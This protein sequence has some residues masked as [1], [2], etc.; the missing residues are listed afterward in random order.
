MQKS[1]DG[2]LLDTDV[3]QSSAKQ[4]ERAEWSCHSSDS[5]Q[6]EQAASAEQGG[7]HSQ[8]TQAGL[9][10]PGQVNHQ[11]CNTAGKVPK[12]VVDTGRKAIEKAQNEHIAKAL[13]IIDTSMFMHCALTACGCRTIQG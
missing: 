5:E 11:A 12:P 1:A 8:P 9:G 2:A 7:V 13:T 10:T 4:R 3:T 6:D